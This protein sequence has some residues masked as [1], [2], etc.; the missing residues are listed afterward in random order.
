MNFQAGYIAV[1][2]TLICAI[3]IGCGTI[4]HGTTQDVSVSSSP[5]GAEVIIDGAD[6]GETPITQS[7]D[8]G[9]QH[10]IELSLEGYESESII[11]NKGVSGWVIGNIVFGGLIG[12]VVDAASGG[13]YKLEP[14]EI[15]RSLGEEAARLQEEGG[16]FITVV[17]ETNPNWEKIGQ[18]EPIQ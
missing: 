5:S 14:T 13:M 10:T 12:L 9:S 16:V 18:L 4:I 2:A 1:T 3:L 17:M 7:L 8:R 6:V 11:V 15:S